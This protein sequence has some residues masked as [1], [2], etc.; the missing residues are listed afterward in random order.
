LALSFDDHQS[1]KYLIESLSL[2][3][4]EVGKMEVNG[5]EV[6]FSYK[7]KVDKCISVFPS[8]FGISTEPKLAANGLLGRL[9]AYLRMQRSDT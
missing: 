4:V 3:H 6:E 9:A 8:N 7:S 2:S 1:I 5:V